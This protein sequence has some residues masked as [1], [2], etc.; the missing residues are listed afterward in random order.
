[1]HVSRLP[2]LLT[3]SFVGVLLLAGPAAA[4]VTVKSTDAKQGGYATFTFLVP[5]EKDIA[6]TKIEV[7]FPADA[8]LGSVRTKPVP[9]WSAVITKTKPAT[10]LKDAHGGTIDLVVSAITW[11]A[12]TGQ[13]ITASQ[14]QEFAV[15][16]GPLPKV[17]RLVFKTLQTYA[18]GS[19]VRWIEQ[20]PAGSTTMPDHPAP[21][22]TLAAP[23]AAPAA[24]PTQ[25]TVSAAP[26]VSATVA[27]VPA[28]S[29]DNTGLGI[30]GLSV[31]VVAALLALAALLRGRKNQ[32]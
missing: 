18:D 12:A 32:P 31:A 20:A 24:S 21:V 6:T 23:A 22:L 28:A 7:A 1:M 29:S 3:A 11:T 13:G 2:A 17:D 10:P 19:V 16:A 27:D 30:A 15:S 4:H 9:G 14:F 8:A 26:S 25:V 5:S